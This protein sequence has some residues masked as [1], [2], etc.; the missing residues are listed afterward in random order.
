MVICLSQLR[1]IEF[2]LICSPFMV[3]HTP[4]VRRAHGACSLTE[5]LTVVSLQPTSLP[6]I[7]VACSVHKPVGFQSLSFG[8]NCEKCVGSLSLLAGYTGA[9]PC[10]RTSL[11]PLGR[12][13]IRFATAK[14]RTRP[15][16]TKIKRGVGGCGGR[17]GQDT[18]GP[19]PT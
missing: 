15:S 4:P 2:G 3:P 6:A 12:L 9:F 7:Q 10:C 16:G 11:S 17:D 19:P 5:Q 14:R 1:L 18:I 13:S 8:P